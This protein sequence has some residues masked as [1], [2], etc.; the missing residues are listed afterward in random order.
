VEDLE[1][2]VVVDLDTRALQDRVFLVK[3]LMVVLEEMKVVM[4]LV[5][6]AAQ[7]ASVEMEVLL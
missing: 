7:V 5:V 3:V 4:V 6:A 2:L 1:D